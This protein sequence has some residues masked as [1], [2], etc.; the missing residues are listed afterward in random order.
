MKKSTLLKAFGLLTLLFVFTACNRYDEGSNFSLLTAK[1]RL[2]NTWTVS[3]ISYTLGSTTTQV[4]GTSGTITI[5]KD[6]NWNSSF[7]Y[8]FLGQQVTETQTGTWVFNDDKTQV[9]TTDS[10]GDT[11]TM[12]IVKLK[13]K[14]LALTTTDNNGGITR[15]DYTGE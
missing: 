1:A 11:Q 15:T 14:E 13:N 3:S 8:T 10:D 6:G 5:E 9:I 2:A 7:T 12:T 4:T